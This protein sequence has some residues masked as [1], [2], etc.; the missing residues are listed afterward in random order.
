MARRTIWL[1]DQAEN[2][3]TTRN[4]T[5][6]SNIS[7]HINAAFEQ[8][9][10]ILKDEKP[11]LNDIEMAEIY[12]IYTGSDLTRIAL[13]ANIAS[14]ML[15]HYGATLPSQLPEHCQSLIERLAAMSQ[16][17]QIALIDDVRLF[18]ASQ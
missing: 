11:T 9:A 3:I 16:A 6:T 15:T 14:D 1:N 17:Q 5:D 12:N 10:I 2:Y 18:L 4:T 7:G 13:P 8:L